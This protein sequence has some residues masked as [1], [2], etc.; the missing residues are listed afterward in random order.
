MGQKPTGP[1]LSFARRVNEIID[2]RRQELGM[3]KAALIEGSGIPANTFHTRMR[4]DRPFD[5]NDIENIARALRCDAELILR[6]ASVGTLIEQDVAPVT[7][8]EP[9]RRVRRARKDVPAAA[10]PRDADSGE[11]SDAP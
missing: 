3:T 9:R 5:L 1:A 10:R 7:P 2:A 11:D 4:G 6:E 8:L